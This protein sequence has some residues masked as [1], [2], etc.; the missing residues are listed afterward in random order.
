MLLLHPPDWVAEKDE[1]HECMLSFVRKGK[2]RKQQILPLWES[3]SAKNTFLV[4]LSLLFIAYCAVPETL[5]ACHRLASS[6]DS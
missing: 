6:L 3:V 1:S 4:S 5:V 2:H